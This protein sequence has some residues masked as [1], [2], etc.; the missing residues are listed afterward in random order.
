MKRVLL[1]NLPHPAPVQ[2]R[3]VASYQAPN[4]LLPPPEPM[5]LASFLKREGV[6][7]RLVDAIAER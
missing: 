6:A 5:A 1:V 7:V 2:R 3:W 4:F